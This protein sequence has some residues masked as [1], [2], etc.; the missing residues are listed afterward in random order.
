M[1]IYVIY[2]SCA[3]YSGLLSIRRKQRTCASVETFWGLHIKK[4]IIS[5]TMDDL[6]EH[7]VCMGEV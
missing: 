2:C 6:F 4:K 1:Y 7:A 5:D 3:S